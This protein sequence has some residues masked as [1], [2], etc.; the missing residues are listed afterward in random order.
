MSTGSPLAD[1][2]IPP[3]GGSPLAWAVGRLVVG[4]AL[5]ATA[6]ILIAGPAGATTVTVAP[7]QDLTSI[8]RTNGTTVS[9]LEAAN[10]I[11]NPG[12]VYAGAVLQIP[13][14]TGATP[15][16]TTAMV[17]PGEDLTSIAR[18]YGITLAVLEAANGIT[19]PNLV[20][21]G[22]MLQIP[23]T[24]PTPQSSAPP[25]ATTVV[26]AVGEDLTTIARQNATTV[27]A[28]VSA[29][30]ITNPNVV[31][32]GTILHLPA[33]WVLSDYS[34]ATTATPGA[35]PAEAG[36]PAALVADPSRI[37]LMPDFVSAAAAYDLPPS[38][39]E[40]MC[41][42]ES[43]WQP[44]VVSPTGAIGLCQLEPYTTAFVNSVLLG[45]ANLSATI[46]GQNIT[47]AAAFLHYL[48]T[49]TGGSERQSLAG[50]YQ[51]LLSVQQ[52]G[53]LASTQTYVQGILAYAAMFATN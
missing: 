39:L 14:S 10:G 34:A 20:K 5:A 48:L 32:A 38:L 45:G 44:A 19:N 4:M 49:L 36:L 11:T 2:P 8:A 27:A 25:V 40:A 53:M 24:T 42:W 7:G 15:A 17:A 43:G 1:A 21:A 52:T 6:V 37:A 46:P 3:K 47:L 50:Y 23:S 22:T 41:W 33:T 28:L 18:K 13:G 51:G 35:T 26:V 16:S 9:A 31:A 29:N 12:L 30:D